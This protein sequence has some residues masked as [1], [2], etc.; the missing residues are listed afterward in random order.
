MRGPGA[1]AAAMPVERPASFGASARR[2]ASWIRPVRLAFAVA[3][4]LT[5]VSVAMNVAGPALLGAATNIVYATVTGDQPLDVDG[6]RDVL[7][8]ALG[9]YLVGTFANWG[10]GVLLNRVVQSVALRMRERV[11]AKLH[12]LPLGYFDRMPRGELLSRV[13]N[14]VDNVAQSLQQVLSQLVFSLLTIVGIVGM[15]LVLSPLLALVAL[16]TVP[17]TAVVASAVGRR[18]QPRFAEQW[19]RTGRLGAQVEEAYAG[20][21]LV[22][23][24]GRRR[25]V[26]ARFREENDALAEAAFTAQFLSGIIMPAVMAI[27]NLG[28]VLV[29][30]VGALL[31]AGGALS[32]GSVQAFI[33]Y[34]RQLGH[35]IGQIGAMV[36]LMQSGVA[37]AERVFA[38][39]DAAELEPDPASPQSPPPDAAEVVFDDVDF[40]YDPDTPLIRDLSLAVAP[41]HTVAIVGPTGAGKTT[42]VNLL[43]RFYE[44]DAGRILLDGVDTRAMTRDDLRSR[45]G[46]VLQDTW[47]FEGTIRENIRY[48]RLDASD[49]EVEAAARAAHADRFIRALPDGYDTLLA[50][51]GDNVSAGQKQLLTIARAV[52]A[53]PRILILDEATSS[54]DTRT[55]LLIQRAM[56]ELRRDRTSFVIAHRLSTIRDAQLILVMESGR[57][58]EQG[59]HAALMAAGG[60]YA[61]LVRVQFQGAGE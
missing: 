45:T 37:S 10:Q 18:S 60:A 40:A 57:I 47:L 2:L 12:R 56:A 35:P 61:R 49:G 19:A 21:A 44:V 50:A 48:G 22:K 36:N 39:L 52:L 15:M 46:M 3:V 11:E 27:G 31:V 53:A 8:V 24:F 54:V 4:A 9:A 42:L 38:L 33:Q 6:L 13:T 55:E 32:L 59:D 20:H 34:S 43:M 23:V 1:A 30:V 7:A 25:E 5:A 51:D 28:Y 29:A 41:G 14:D 16:V 58:V 17:L 26:A